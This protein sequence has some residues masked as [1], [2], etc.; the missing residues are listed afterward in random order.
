MNDYKMTEY[1]KL[2]HDKRTK[3]KYNNKK[4]EAY[5]VTNDKYILTRL[6]YKQ[7]ARDILDNLSDWDNV[8][9]FLNDIKN[10][11]TGS[12]VLWAQQEQN[13]KKS[14][15]QKEKELYKEFNIKSTSSDA[16]SDESFIIID[17]IETLSNVDKE[18]E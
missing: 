2:L 10:N 12:F 4:I 3:F 18:N 5:F 9:D 7:Y 16:F 15:K 1:G 11:A 8:S 14:K 17:M 13:K 6:V